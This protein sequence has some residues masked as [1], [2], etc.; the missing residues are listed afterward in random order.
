MGFGS[1]AWRCGQEK[2][3]HDKVLALLAGCVDAGFWL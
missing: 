3:L 1:F 2:S